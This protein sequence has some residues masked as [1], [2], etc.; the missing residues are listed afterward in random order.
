M[1]SAPPMTTPIR[2]PTI[3]TGLRSVVIT[4]DLLDRLAEEAADGERQR[5]GRQ[6]APGLDRVDGLAGDGQ[7]LRELALAQALR[8]PELPHLVLH[9]V[10]VPLQPPRCQ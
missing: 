5:E 8:L 2:T 3:T 7:P 9:A 4:E 10:K 1:S 6:V